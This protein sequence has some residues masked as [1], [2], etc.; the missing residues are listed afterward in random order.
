MH[1]A[2]NVVLDARAGCSGARTTVAVSA[3]GT[4]PV[5]ERA[6]PRAAV[7]SG[8]IRIGPYMAPARERIQAPRVT[9]H[10]CA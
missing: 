3:W 1:G 8:A 9:E 7:S 4:V 10:V 2:G 6:H 5:V